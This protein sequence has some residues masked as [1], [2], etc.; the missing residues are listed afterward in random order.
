MPRPEVTTVSVLAIDPQNS[1]T[2]YAGTNGGGVLAISFATVPVLTLNS[3]NYCIGAP[4]TL[5]VSN[6]APSISLR[7]LGTTSGKSWA[8]P[9]WAKTDGNGNFSTTGV[10]GQGTEGE[11]T[12]RVEAGGVFSNAV[13]FVVSNCKP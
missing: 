10:M 3:T 5:K 8:I 6:A 12:L 13:S 1:S 2:L 11:Y 9:G 7:L 4:W